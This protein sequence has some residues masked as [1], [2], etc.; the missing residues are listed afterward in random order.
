MKNNP[1]RIYND[2]MKK[3]RATKK[4]KLVIINNSGWK[5]RT[6]VNALVASRFPELAKVGN[7]YA[8]GRDAGKAQDYYE[9]LVRD[10]SGFLRVRRES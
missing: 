8:V 1:S 6:A 3:H 5:H 10:K 4:K 7:A 9:Q 2:G